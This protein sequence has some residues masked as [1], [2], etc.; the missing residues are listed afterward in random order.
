MEVPVNCCC[1]NYT[2][3]PVP[4]IFRLFNPLD[5]LK[6]LQ[7]IVKWGSR[8]LF[9]HP[10][11]LRAVQNSLDSQ[12]INE[13]YLIELARNP[14]GIRSGMDDPVRGNV[15]IFMPTQYVTCPSC[16]VHFEHVQTSSDALPLCKYFQPAAPACVP[17]SSHFR[18]EELEMIGAFWVSFHGERDT[19]RS[20]TS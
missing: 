19:I 10:V 4:A 12:G 14:I 5:S 2:I 15:K 17:A 18:F 3:E 13:T 11:L 6:F 8:T 9:Q 7:M 1:Y 16:L 20:P